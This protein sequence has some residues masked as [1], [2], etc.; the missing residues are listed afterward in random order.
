MEI[1]KVREEAAQKIAPWHWAICS[2]RE[3]DIA[4][5]IVDQILKLRREF[6]WQQQ[7]EQEREVGRREVVEWIRVNGY[8][9]TDWYPDAR[10]RW[11]ESWQAKLKEWGIE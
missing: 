6:T 7:V 1:D 2:K 10:E 9:N 3:R 11:E 8:L 5:D 4:L